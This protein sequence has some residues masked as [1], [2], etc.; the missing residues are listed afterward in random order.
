MSFNYSAITLYSNV[1]GCFGE[2]RK[3]I[4][5]RQIQVFP[6]FFVRELSFSSPS[7]P[8]S[9][10]EAHSYV[11]LHFFSWRIWQYFFLRQVI[12]I[13]LIHLY[14]EHHFCTVT[15]KCF[16]RGTCVLID[17][18]FHF[19]FF[20][21]SNNN[22]NAEKFLVA[23]WLGGADGP[24]QGQRSFVTEE[25]RQHIQ[26][27]FPFRAAPSSACLLFLPSCPPPPPL[28]SSNTPKFHCDSP[29]MSFK[30]LGLDSLPK[31]SLAY[32]FGV[33]GWLI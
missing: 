13:S 4:L 6:S 8:P 11:E 33:V 29:V 21:L 9:G 26:P 17:T 32:C 27:V 31:S 25:D 23:T 1:F 20:M 24:E 5:D 22:Q 16:R 2:E 18:I 28:P 10:L 7:T 30:E 14:F 19:L 15:E 3:Y 12:T